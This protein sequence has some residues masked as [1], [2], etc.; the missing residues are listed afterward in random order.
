[1]ACHKNLNTPKTKLLILSKVTILLA[2]KT[3]LAPVRPLVTGPPLHC[4]SWDHP[5]MR[6][7]RGSRDTGHKL[8]RFR[9]ILFAR[10]LPDCIGGISRGQR[11]APAEPELHHQTLDGTQMLG[12]HQ[13]WL[14]GLDQGRLPWIAV[15]R[16]APGV[17]P[18]PKQASIT[19]NAR[20]APPV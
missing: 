19:A 3:Q 8:R 7:P 14:M 16:F 4:V 20:P 13:G 11:A 15:L 17:K 6:D 1:M 5:K 12:L 18:P 10:T 9:S 2:K